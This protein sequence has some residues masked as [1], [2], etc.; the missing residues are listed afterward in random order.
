[1]A[2]VVRVSHGGGAVVE[3]SHL[4]VEQARSV[5][6]SLA[7]V[8][9]PAGCCWCVGLWDEEEEEEVAGESPTGKKAYV[10]EG[11]SSRH[12]LNSGGDPL[13]QL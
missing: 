13:P 4:T 5:A 9:E 7:T 1:V 10:R 6:S 3:E 11:S 8:G 12:L 2:S